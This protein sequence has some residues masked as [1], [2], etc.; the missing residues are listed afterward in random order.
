MA[1]TGPELRQWLHEEL[2]AACALIRQAKESNDEASAL[3]H[4][5]EMHAIVRVLR[6]AVDGEDMGALFDLV[7]LIVGEADFHISELES[8]DGREG[9]SDP[10][11]SLRRAT[12]PDIDTIASWH[13]LPAD[14]VLRWWEDPEVVPWVMLDA[15]G[16][17]VGYGEIWLDP[18]EDEVE[19]A[20]LIVAPELRG[21]GL[22]KQLTRLLTAKAAETQLATTMLRVTPDNDV[23]INC[24]LRCGFERLG[25]EESAIWNEGQHLAWV[26][27][28]Y[29]GG[30]SDAPV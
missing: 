20:R 18:A 21:H 8:L 14:E 16:E 7:A 5:G 12:E 3:V 19:L 28:V 17:M 9:E 15:D 1:M 11:E 6:H 30:S 29:R 24:Y 13:P 10:V 26:W 22:G 2:D 27:M 4:R 23:A 25:P